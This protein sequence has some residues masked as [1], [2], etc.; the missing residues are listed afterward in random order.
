MV[1]NNKK[2]LPFR[3]SFEVQIA[4]VIDFYELKCRMCANGS[5]IIEGQDYE[6]SY[7]PTADRESLRFFIA[8]VSEKRRSYHASMH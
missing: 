1:P 4:D 7:T 6:I 8:I 3:L 5:K 2:V